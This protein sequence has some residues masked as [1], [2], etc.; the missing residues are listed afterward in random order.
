M[1][2]HVGLLTLI[3]LSSA[4]HLLAFEANGPQG[5]L[6]TLAW[7]YDGQQP[8]QARLDTDWYQGATRRAD[9]ADLDRI[10]TAIGGAATIS[11]N[12]DYHPLGEGYFKGAFVDDGTTDIGDGD[13]SGPWR[14][15]SGFLGFGGKIP[16]G[17]RQSIVGRGR[18]WLTDGSTTA[19][20]STAMTS[21]GSLGWRQ[22]DGAEALVLGLTYRGWSG[23]EFVTTMPLPLVEYHWQEEVWSGLLGFPRL[24]CRWSPPGEGYR[25]WLAMIDATHTAMTEYVWLHHDWP[26]GLRIGAEVVL[27]YEPNVREGPLTRLSHRVWLHILTHWRELSFSIGPSYH[28]PER[29]YAGYIGEDPPFLRIDERWGGSLTM[30]WVH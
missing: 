13:P 22:G 3:I 29:W 1:R 28:G 2:W 21:E 8:W 9:Q 17:R 16:L 14:I 27:D 10:M 24:A 5:P 23:F 20:G 19:V 26:L 30:T 4:H 25:S 12:P 7:R 6:L 18:L 15:L 11:M